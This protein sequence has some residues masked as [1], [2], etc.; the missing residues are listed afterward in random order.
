MSILGW[1][2]NSD[3]GQV[4]NFGADDA[5]DDVIAD[6]E[7]SWEEVSDRAETYVAAD[8]YYEGYRD[9]WN[10]ACEEPRR[11]LFGIF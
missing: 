1:M 3:Y 6:R 10:K 7:R 9:L 8:A 2:F 11:K 5:A 4:Y